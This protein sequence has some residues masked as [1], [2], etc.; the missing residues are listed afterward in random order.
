MM[1]GLWPHAR[2]GLIA[3]V[4]ESDGGCVHPPLTVTR[5]DEEGCGSFLHALEN[6][7]GLDYE[8]VLPSNLVRSEALAHVSLAWGVPLWVVPQALAAAVRTLLPT[9]P[10]HRIATALARLPL[11]PALR[12]HLRRVVPADRRQL[13]LL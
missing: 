8:L 13:C 6:D 10:P 2:G 7:V 12:C 9:G 11:A 1:V 3:S 4:V 5:S